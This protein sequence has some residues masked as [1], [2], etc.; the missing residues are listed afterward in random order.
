[1][2]APPVKAPQ[3][4]ITQPTVLTSAL[5]PPQHM[6]SRPGVGM[7]NQAMLRLVSRRAENLAR[8]ASDDQ[9]QDA[10]PERMAVPETAP[11]LA[12]DFSKI[13]LFPPEG[14]SRPQTSFPLVQPK[15]AIG[16]V[17]DPLEHEADRISEQVMQMPEPQLQRACAC[18]GGCS[19]CQT[20]GHERLQTKQVGTGDLGQTAAPPIV[21]E[22]MRS[23]GQPL[24]PAIRGFME[25]RF[26]CDF[27]R[28]RVHTDTRS[29]ESAKVI[30][31]RAY[32]VG[33]EVVFG[34]NQ[35]AP[36]AVEGRRLLAHELTHVIQQGN[37]S[38]TKSNR[39]YFSP[40]STPMLFL[41]RK[42]S[43][44]VTGIATCF[45]R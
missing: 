13:P 32:T 31:A 29:A 20:G 41:Q 10:D 18:G 35:Y 28:V 33:S 1:M 15:L 6:L 23:P 19:E 40:L 38:H 36:S 8:S 39:L 43:F 30:G 16:Q 42:S 37:T 22:V 12:W 26:G 5:K 17:N 7:S 11:S 3:A 24:D 44:P 34:A 9:K 2:F 25:P 21:H 4:K 14:A 45:W 27:N